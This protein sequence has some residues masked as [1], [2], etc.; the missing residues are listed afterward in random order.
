[1]IIGVDNMSR[2]TKMVTTYYLLL[3]NSL[4]LPGTKLQV[5]YWVVQ[6]AGSENRNWANHNG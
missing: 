6:Q 4:V 2:C 3:T 1:M 5:G